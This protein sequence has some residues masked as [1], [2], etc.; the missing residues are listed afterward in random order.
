[1]LGAHKG[2]EDDDINGYVLPL[3]LEITAADYGIDHRASSVTDDRILVVG[4]VRCS[5]V[6]QCAAVA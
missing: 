1:M 3:G 5:L 4:Q 2:P 6:L